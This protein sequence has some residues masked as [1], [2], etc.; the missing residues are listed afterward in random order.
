MKNQPQSGIKVLNNKEKIEKTPIIKLSCQA[1]RAQGRKRQK[2]QQKRIKQLELSD[3]AKNN[4]VRP[5][6]LTTW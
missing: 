3:S 5:T 6:L 2:E 1:L 4:R